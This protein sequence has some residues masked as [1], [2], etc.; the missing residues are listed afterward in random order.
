LEPYTQKRDRRN[1]GT[2]HNRREIE[3]ILEP[4]TTEEK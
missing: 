4:Y 3:E 1:I 2:I